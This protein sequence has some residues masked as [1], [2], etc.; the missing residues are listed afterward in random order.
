MK[1]SHQHTRAREVS[2]TLRCWACVLAAS[3]AGCAYT[4]SGT[5]ASYNYPVA[6]YNNGMPAATVTGN[7]APT[8]PFSFYTS[9]ANYSLTA[10]AS[11]ETCPPMANWSGL[12]E[13]G[14]G[15]SVNT[16]VNVQIS[17]YPMFIS[18]TVSGYNPGGPPI[19]ITNN[20]GPP[21]TI[22]SNGVFRFATSSS[23]NVIQLPANLPGN[24][25]SQNSNCQ[26]A[27]AD[28][29]LTGTA[30]TV[31]N[32][33]IYCQT[34]IPVPPSNFTALQNQPPPS[35]NPP[36]PSYVALML[37]MTDGTV[38]ANQ[39]GTVNWFRLTPDSSGHYVNGKWSTIATSHCAH[40]Q[41]ASQVLQDGRVFVAGGELPG[42]TPTST[43]TCPVVSPQAATS[44]TA[45]V[46][47]QNGTGVETEI[48]DPVANTWTA[49]TP[50]TSL[51]DPNAAPANYGPASGYGDICPAQSFQDMTSALLDSGQVLM[52]PVCPKNCG[53]T[54][55]FDP[56]KFSPT[57]A[58]S[59]WSLAG[60]LANTAG[61]EFSCSEQE[62]S[63]VKLQDGSVL[64]ADP[65]TIP[66]ALET[67]ERYVPSTSS[68]VPDRNLG[69]TLFNNFY[70]WDVDG[71]EGPAFLLPDGRAI[72]I[73]GSS[74]Y[75]IYTPGVSGVMGSWQQ[76]PL[77]LNGPATAG[78]ALAADDKPG[79]MMANGKILLALNYA[80]ATDN[81]FPAPVF[82]YEFDPSQT[83]P[84]AFTEVAGPPGAD[85]DPWADCAP[86]NPNP[87]PY[88]NPMLPLPD[89]T[90]L[91]TGGCN[92]SQ[93]YVYQSSGPPLQQGQPTIGVG[94]AGALISQVSPISNTFLL[95]GSGLTGISEGAS[96]G[97]DAQMSS[98]YPL[99]QLTDSTGRV[100]YARTHDWLSLAVAPG[101]SGNTHFDVPLST[102]PNLYQLRVVVNGNPSAPVN[103]TWNCP[104]GNVWIPLP[105]GGL[106][107]PQ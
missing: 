66:G 12:V 92:Q 78:A 28:A 79:V 8:N 4:I 99:V 49:A 11:G 48:Y 22:S 80:A 94:P 35:N 61:T 59:G 82:F 19:Y 84:N 46:L 32:V 86:G 56:T 83:G 10:T 47:A 40:G 74:V 25:A 71:E 2:F 77:P 65:P 57:T 105:P 62:T 100:F 87:G 54:L 91:T 67:S 20:N 9:N 14:F 89:G 17:C 23:S 63:W 30:A 76:Y 85:L 39:T 64:T 96:F 26:I 60:K 72:F 27:N 34:T 29:E 7:G 73:G 15:F 53:D 69:F 103:F 16:A 3:A 37:L 75:G 21:F 1:K 106:C 93:L 45:A 44:T 36:Y 81:P 51:I 101:A 42:G 88:F 55:I 52:A 102:P 24:P 31:A 97:D 50:P 13:Q 95:A 104:Q 90:V 33:E 18:G 6:I 38:I 5:V 58:G 98:N 43:S 107:V 70:G 68:W 41:F